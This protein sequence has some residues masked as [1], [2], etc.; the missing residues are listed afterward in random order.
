MYCFMQVRS[1][2]AQLVQLLAGSASTSP[3]LTSD[4]ANDFSS[5]IE[6][7]FRRRETY[8]SFQRELTDDRGT[9]AGKKGPLF[10]VDRDKSTEDEQ[11]WR[12]PGN[13]QVLD[14]AL[15]ADAPVGRQLSRTYSPRRAERREQKSIS[16]GIAVCL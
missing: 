1:G 13:G 15:Y 2:L 6:P 5:T 8:V 10:C 9:H 3:I 12:N 16:Y 11:G 14:P 7:D 4:P